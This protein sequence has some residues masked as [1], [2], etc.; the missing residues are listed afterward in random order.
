LSESFGVAALDAQAC[1]ITVVAS[2]VGGLREV[3]REG[4]GGLFAPPADPEALAAQLLQL[5]DSPDQRRAMGLQARQWVEKHF[6]WQENAARMEKI[7]RS[8]L[9]DKL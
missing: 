4:V 7:Y 6:D 9:R 2:D 3:V 1:G 8:L 5:A